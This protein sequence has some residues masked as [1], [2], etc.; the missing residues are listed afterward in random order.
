M[1][2]KGFSDADHR[3]CVRMP[4]WFFSTSQHGRC[5]PLKI[6]STEMCSL[7]TAEMKP[8]TVLKPNHKAQFVS[9]N[10]VVE[11]VKGLSWIWRQCL[12]PSNTE[13]SRNSSPAMSG[14][15]RYRVRA[16]SLTSMPQDAEESL[17]GWAAGKYCSLMFA[18]YVFRSF[19]LLMSRPCVN[20]RHCS[21]CVCCAASSLMDYI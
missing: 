7:Q 10:H 2:C 16:R 8:S 19:F 5:A 20:C 1:D 13:C 11:I 14:G 4:S 15:Y 18:W 21:V 17:S 12:R 3:C 6:I 9:V